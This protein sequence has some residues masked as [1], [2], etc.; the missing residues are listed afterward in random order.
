MNLAK[1]PG[2]ERRG[3]HTLGGF[4]M[5]QIG[6]VPAAA[7]IFEAQGLRFEVVD[8]DENRVDKVLVQR[9]KDGVL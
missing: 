9:K 7:D 1:L 3:Y 2:E 5:V 8:M 4:V 6:R